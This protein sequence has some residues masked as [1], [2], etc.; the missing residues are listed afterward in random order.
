MQRSRHGF[1]L[2][3]LLVVITIIGILIA[4]LLPAVQAAREAARRLQCANNLKQIS[5]AA[6]QHHEQHGVFPSGGWGFLWVGDPD[7]GTGPDQPGAWGYTLLPFLEQTALHQL[8]ADGDPK[9]ITTKQKEGGTQLVQTPLS[10]YT[11]PSRRQ[12]GAWPVLD[13][14][15]WPNQHGTLGGLKLNART[16]YA[17]C[18]GDPPLPHDMGGPNSLAIGDGWTAAGTWHQNY[19]YPYSVDPGGISFIRSQIDI[20]QIRDGT[21][22]TY[23]IGEKYLSPDHYFTGECA[24]DNQSMYSGYN[25]DNHRSV[26]ANYPPMQDRR[27]AALPE[28]FG[29]AHAGSFNMSFCDGSVRSISYAIDSE[30]H[31]R[32][33]LRSSNLPIDASKF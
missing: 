21:S 24:G 20:A 2:V 16:D 30:T 6:H 17:A 25:H 14:H 26:R 23:L 33:G 22:N 28:N 18:A 32:L 7:R 12:P 1:T 15:N 10:V 31:R 5:L 29:S 9:T 19:S 27:G 13:R 8:G 11:C 4:L 3:E